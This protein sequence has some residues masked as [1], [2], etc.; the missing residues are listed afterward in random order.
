ME[1]FAELAMIR[2]H[3]AFGVLSPA[4]HTPRVTVDRLVVERERWRTEP[5]ELSFAWETDEWRRFRSVGQWRER[6]GMPQHVFVQTSRN[7]KPT[8][9]DLAAPVLVDLLAR[10]IRRAADRA[11]PVVVSEMLPAPDQLWLPDAAGRRY[12]SELRLVAINRV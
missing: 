8:Y 12:T 2:T 7:T 11:E 9:V 6:H 4:E 1:L 10:T 3:Q 5:G